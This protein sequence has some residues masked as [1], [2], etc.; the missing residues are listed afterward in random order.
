MIGVW[1][2]EGEWQGH[3]RV[4]VVIGSEGGWGM[5]VWGDVILGV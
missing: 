1:C 5:I 4:G 2:V 3:C